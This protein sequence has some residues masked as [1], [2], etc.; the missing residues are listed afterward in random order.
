MSHA[1]L[2]AL[3]VTSYL[4]STWGFERW[5]RFRRRLSNVSLRELSRP[6]ARRVLAPLGAAAEPVIRALETSALDEA[7]VAAAALPKLTPPQT[8]L[9]T[10]VLA[11]SEAHAAT[12]ELARYRSATRAVSAARRA[13][14]LGAPAAYLEAIALLGFLADVVTQDLRLWQARRLLERAEGLSP[15]DP[16]LQLAAALHA[17]VAG[18]PSESVAALARALYHA[19]DD[20]FVIA[21][22]QAAPYVWELSPGLVEE[23]RQGR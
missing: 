17:A 18:Q 9:L 21:R 8:A 2:L 6:H 16:L 10:A 20:A 7:R 23:T 15:P 22:I 19:R 4:A 13:R 11:L 5:R 1:E 14:E 3:V 12:T